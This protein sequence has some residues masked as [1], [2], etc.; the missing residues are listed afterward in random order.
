[1]P[2]EI[3]VAGILKK[4]RSYLNKVLLP[5]WIE[6]SPDPKFGG[7]LTHFDEECFWREGVALG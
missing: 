4:T 7:Y 2:P 5:F 6:N 1:M 3:E